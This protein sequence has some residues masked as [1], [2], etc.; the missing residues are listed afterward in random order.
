[1]IV[2]TLGEIYRLRYT[3]GAGFSTAVA[4][5]YIGGILVAVI[6]CWAGVILYFFRRYAL[7]AWLSVATVIV[8]IV[9][10][11]GVIGR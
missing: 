4:M 3:L 6:C 11:I 8:L 1:M 9:Y 2:R 7:C 5:P 10:K